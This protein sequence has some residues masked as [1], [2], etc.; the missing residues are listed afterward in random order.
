LTTLYLY[1]N[2][3]YPSFS[4]PA[5]L[6]N[7]ANLDLYFNDLTTVTLP[8]SLTGLSN[9]DIGYNYLTS[10][11]LPAA[12]TRLTTLNLDYNQLTRFTLPPGLTNLN[13]LYLTGNQL[14]SLT[15]PAGLTS[16][17]T[18]YLFGNQLTSFTLPTGLS[19][20]NTLDLSQNHLTSVTF[21]PGVMNMSY[22]NL[23]NN[24]LTTFVL[25][26]PLAVTDLADTVASL[27]SRSVSVYAYPPTVSLVSPQ[28]TSAGGLGFTLTGPP[29]YY[30]IFS[31][32]NLTAW[33]QIRTVNNRLGAV[34]FTDSQATNSSQQF[35]RALTT[36]P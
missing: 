2:F 26:E 1:D 33:T 30:N 16:L 10:F 35:Y 9:L 6:T 4:L 3:L 34:F 29:A 13:S 8:S 31:S 32:T 19:S 20:L 17:T 27:T 5:G 36:A 11:T 21:L 18:L 15:L 7:L 14:T 12:L 22:L 23:D 28:W 25:P 24:P